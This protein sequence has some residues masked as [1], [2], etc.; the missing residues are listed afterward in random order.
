MREILAVM[1]ALADENRLRVVAALRGRELCV[2]QIVELLGLAN[3]TVSRHMSLLHQARI[4]ESRKDGRWSYFRLATKDES[5]EAAAAA[6]L[7][8]ASLTRDGKIRS[9][10]K[11][12]K[13]ILKMD[14]E[15]LCRQQSECKS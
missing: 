7:A 4:V 3:S 2:C 1:K 15:V 8:L 12:L 5:P 13:Q 9:D 6:S 11:R 10:A 14:P